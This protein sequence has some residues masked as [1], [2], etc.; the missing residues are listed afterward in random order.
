MLA[1]FTLKSDHSSFYARPIN[2]FVQISLQVIYLSRNRLT[3][4]N[5]VEQFTNLKAFSA[6]DN[7]LA[8]FAS[9]ASLKNLQS[10][11]A[12]SL[13]CNPGADLPNYRARVI[14]MIGQSLQHLDGRPVTAEDRRIAVDICSLEDVLLNLAVSNSILAEYL[15]RALQITQLHSELYISQNRRHK[16]NFRQEYEPFS[17]QVVVGR[18]AAMWLN[19]GLLEGDLVYRSKIEA[20]ITRKVFINHQGVLAKGGKTIS[21]G[22]WHQAWCSVLTNQVGALEDLLISI[23]A[24]TSGTSKARQVGED[25]VAWSGVLRS[26]RQM[27]EKIR[28][29]MPGEPKSQAQQAQQLQQQIFNMHGVLLEILSSDKEEI[30]SSQMDAQQDWL[31]PATRSMSE[32]LH[33]ESPSLGAMT[34]G[35]VG[36]PSMLA[37]ASRRSSPSKQPPPLRRSQPDI[38][39]AA[40]YALQ[41]EENAC[42]KMQLDNAKSEASRAQQASADQAL[43]YTALQQEQEIAQETITSLN[44]WLE[45]ANSLAEEADAEKEDLITQLQSL[46]FHLQETQAAE[47][48]SRA[49][50]ARVQ[51]T[52]ADLT[53]N[54]LLLK[55]ELE[56]AE[57]AVKDSTQPITLQLDIS[58][59]EELEGERTKTRSLSFELADASQ[60]ATT[61]EAELSA[62]RER[63]EREAV[64]AEVRA[65]L[66]A[67]RAA[68]LARVE[69]YALG[70]RAR[71][72]A[73]VGFTA[74]RKAALRSQRIDELVQRRKKALMLRVL[75]QWQSYTRSAVLLAAM[76]AAATAAA[77]F[78]LV[79]RAFASW[80]KV[81]KV[82]HQVDL[83]SDSTIMLTAT[84]GHYRHVIK[85]AFSAWKECAHASSTTRKAL[86]ILT[87][88]QRESS[89]L[90]AFFTQWRIVAQEKKEKRAEN[91][92]GTA[93][94]AALL[95]R[96]AL[97]GWQRQTQKSTALA[98]AEGAASRIYRRILLS[99]ALQAWLVILVDCADE[100]A[101][102]KRRETAFIIAEQR[103][104]QRQTIA[105]VA[106][107]REAL[108]AWRCS[109]VSEKHLQALATWS[110]S[111]GCR[112]LQSRVFGIWRAYTLEQRVVSLDEQI[113]ELEEVLGG[114]SKELGF[115]ETQLGTVKELR[116]D[117]LSQ[118][119]ELTQELIAARE[120]LEYLRHETGE[121]QRKLASA[122]TQRSV[123]EQL[124]DEAI[125][126]AQSAALAERRARV[127]A[128]EVI[129]SADSERDAAL[130]T[131]RE[132][133]LEAAAAKDVCTEAKQRAQAA[134]EGRAEAELVAMKA[135]EDASTAAETC[136]ILAEE[137]SNLKEALEGS[138]R[139][140][141]N[142]ITQLEFALN[143]LKELKT[144]SESLKLE[145]A[146]L[147]T[148]AIRLERKLRLAE[149]AK[150]EAEDD[151]HAAIR[152]ANQLADMLEQHAQQ[153]DF[154][155]VEESSG[156]AVGN[157][158]TY[159]LP[160]Q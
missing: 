23:P 72:V 54:T 15:T 143:E 151:A 157:G 57:Q 7:H 122:E 87:R 116:R 3:S 144:A 25:S 158:G 100:R 85:R 82:Y 55:A 150:S 18:L 19:D 146:T 65:H 17:P 130:I 142:L 6:G 97:L 43:A 5:G 119:E 50:L 125:E 102:R 149:E 38:A 59:A 128:Q 159:Q 8:T 9:I 20:D 137:S 27:L 44:S 80:L 10:L 58:F 120:E 141:Q 67:H 148:K 2:L 35:K 79:G 160:W 76:E 1:D 34:N 60:R 75:R 90:G 89:L 16:G 96:K 92:R 93:L 123:A 113:N 109:V 98:A 126:A 110:T 39:L 88:A 105:S 121:L 68:H 94:R 21:P 52:A 138:Q 112:Y 30:E 74:W 64:A 135:M 61:A 124:S 31:I 86:V 154:G 133:R 77:S 24:T 139:R 78:T 56:T 70:F 32:G 129:L 22:T 73:D 66:D 140:N 103:A 101:A 108:V 114:A 153:H 136:E 41:S 104:L 71:R 127:A 40:R 12:V 53:R 69:E 48:K 115:R 13:E 145:E 11:E 111:A 36:V 134:E 46:Q 99:R 118:A 45:R 117:A 91:Q 81:A 106:L 95:M 14:S 156:R 63:Q 49:A 47:Q 62:E 29:M 155:S 83:P 37:D 131:A 51:E 42:L 84:A 152:Q 107:L 33:V 26:L 4:L 132:A 28:Q 147:R